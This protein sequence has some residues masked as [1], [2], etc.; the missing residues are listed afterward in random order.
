MMKKII[1]ILGLLFCDVAY[2][3][4]VPP[5]ADESKISQ[6]I[7]QGAIVG[8]T[9]DPATTVE[10]KQIRDLQFLGFQTVYSQTINVCPSG[11]TYNKVSDGW[12]RALS[13]AHRLFGHGV[14]ILQIA[15]GTYTETNQIYTTD[16][17][18]A[19]INVIGDTADN[20]KVVI[21]FTNI[22]GNNSGGF[23]ADNGGIIG[24]IDGV[25]LNGVG[26]Q[27]AH[28]VASTSWYPQSYGAGIIAQHNAVIA[29]G[30]HVTVNSFYYSVVADDGGM[31]NARG[32]GVTGSDAGD[33]NFMA[34]GNGTIVCTPCTAN[35]AVDM[36]SPSTAILGGGFD[37]ERGGSL[38]IDYSTCTNSNVACVTALSNGKAWA[39]NMTISSPL[40]SQETSGFLAA[41]NGIIE[42]QDST[43]SGM[44][45]AVLAQNGGTAECDRCKITGSYSDGVIADGGLVLGTATQSQGSQTGYGYRA[46]HQ[47]IMHLYGVVSLTSGNKLGKFAVETAG[48]ANSATYNASSISAN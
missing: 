39:H 33:V 8:G 25:T 3:Q 34:R 32:G 10:G 4:H 27:S 11:C 36:T 21:K 43:I 45:I 17:T 31:I 22:K 15:D 44:N 38:Y 12:G 1:A 46:L 13:A 47:G 18:G 40:R 24:L 9:I 29:L 6:T 30:S 48:S 7:S 16:P 2:A 41:E 14:V 42:A 28:S 35:R 26:A 5:H 23:V 37:A 19:S 20:S